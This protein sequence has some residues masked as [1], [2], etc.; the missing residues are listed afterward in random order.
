MKLEKTQ[1]FCLRATAML[2]ALIYAVLF[3]YSFRY[4]MKMVSEVEWLTNTKDSVLWH[5]AFL[6]GV[7]IL[8]YCIKKIDKLLND[9]LVKIA[10]VVISVIITF[11][12]FVWFRLT[13]SYS[14][15]DQFMIL[16][17]A[18]SVAKNM[19]D[20]FSTGDAGN[21]FSMYP[22]QLGLVHIY[23]FLFKFFN[24]THSDVLQ[25]SQAIF[26]GLT[27]FIGFKIT[28]ELFQKKI[29]NI[30]YLLIMSSCFPLF[31][32]SIYIY[33]ESIGVTA[34]FFNIYAMIKLLKNKEERTWKKMLWYVTAIFS[35]TIAYN[36]R[37]GLVVVWVAFA[38]L[39]ILQLLKN[40]KH[41]MPF[42]IV[43]LTL[44]SALCMQSIVK[45]YYVDKT[46]LEFNKGMSPWCW[47]SMGMQDSGREPGE[48]TGLNVY[49]YNLSEGDKEQQ[50]E[51]SQTF[52]KQQAE[53]FIENPEYLIQFYKRKAF[54]QWNE[55]SYGCYTMTRFYIDPPAIVSSLYFGKIHNILYEFM[56][57][58]QSMNYLMIL[59][60]MLYLLLRK[61]ELYQYTIG[62][63]LIGG[64]LFSLIWEAKS[65]YVFPYIVISIPYVAY[66]LFIAQQ[67]LGIL[68]V[69]M[70]NI[71]KVKLF[72]KE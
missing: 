12:G 3:F 20:T 10:A 52:M 53:T 17:T 37:S 54:N 57:Q 48:Y 27:F 41:W 61:H 32:Y 47:L 29:V 36:V 45:N 65:R 46:G 63:I 49:I 14:I 25:Y 70:I 51:L 30:Y 42:L 64:F 33:G 68:T 66:G 19:F 2:G 55:P 11:F 24:N 16:E 26:T 56:N 40:W 62:I 67:Q 58:I 7:L 9:K 5:I 22:H 18:Q 31:F 72:K 59:V 6:I 23:S 1:S 44:I 4:T 43:M 38:I 71:V 39:A 34:I 69:N 8:I 13:E 28:D 15:A 21:Y 50:K 35:F 60:A